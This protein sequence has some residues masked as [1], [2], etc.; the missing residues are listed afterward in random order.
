LSDPKNPLSVLLPR[1]IQAGGEFTD[2]EHQLPADANTTGGD[3]RA[4]R[5]T[6]AMM[7]AP[8]GEPGV[9]SDVRSVYDSR[10]VNAFDFNIPVTA[11]GGE[12]GFGDEPL[13]CEFTV[14]LGFV[15]VLRRIHHYSDNLPPL[16]SRGDVVATLLRDGA[17]V[18]YNEDIPVGVESD[19]LMHFFQVYDENAKVGV[20]FSY[21]SSTP[22]DVTAHFYGNLLPKTG[23][24]ANEEIANPREGI[25]SPVRAR[26]MPTN[27]EPQL[28]PDAPPGA[29]VGGQ[30]TLTR[31][32]VRGGPQK[33]RG[34][35]MRSSDPTKG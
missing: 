34:G 1:A 30:G 7:R 16:P 25:K 22:D 4:S 6:G 33:P 13:T 8:A 35:L 11:T 27:M 9:G 14:P 23:R 21:A 10:P 29:V 19:D 5:L 2:R 24:P 15:L 26:Q 17:A 31:R 18:P 12:N 3:E 20:R 28:A 32:L